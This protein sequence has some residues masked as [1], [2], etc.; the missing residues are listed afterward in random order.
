MPFQGRLRRGIRNPR[1]LKDIAE[2]V[3]DLLRFSSA[4]GF[5]HPG[6]ERDPGG[7]TLP[8][9]TAT[10]H[11]GTLVNIEGT[12]VRKNVTQLDTAIRCYHNL[13]VPVAVAGEPNVNIISAWFAHDGTGVNA[14]STISYNFE[15]GGADAV[16]KDYIDLRF[17]AGGTR[18]VDADHPIKVTLFVVPGER[19]P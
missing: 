3:A 19:W 7:A 17:Y 4:V 10:S 16:N 12:W 8:G 11:P 6:D 5:G 13:D 15:Y 2:R 1:D 9:D 18:T 14:A